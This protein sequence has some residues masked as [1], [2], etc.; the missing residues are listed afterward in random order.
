MDQYYLGNDKEGYSKCF[1]E[2]RHQLFREYFGWIVLAVIVVCGALWIGFTRLKEKTDALAH[3]LEM[4]GW[5]E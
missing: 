4:G 2:Y 5:I 1:S 3:R